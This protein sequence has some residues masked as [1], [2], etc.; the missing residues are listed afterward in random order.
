M[1]RNGK[2]HFVKAAGACLVCA[3][4]LAVTSCGKKENSNNLLMEDEETERAVSMFSPM[5]KTEAD[6]VT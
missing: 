6:T 1:D 2:R 4:M 5:E 3:A